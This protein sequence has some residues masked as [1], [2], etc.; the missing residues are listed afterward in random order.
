MS[1]EVRI[2]IRT[3][4]DIILV[5]HQARALARELGFT[6]SDSTLIAT[7]LSELARNILEYA[8]EGEIVLSRTVKAGRQGLAICAQDKGPGIPDIELALQDGYSTGK[9]LGLGLPGT[10]RL[11]DEF[12]IESGVGQGTVV[13]VVKWAR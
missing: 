5:R 11:V 9:G 1:H 12:D 3:D 10:R 13:R 4:S 2:P 8:G 6:A 7:V